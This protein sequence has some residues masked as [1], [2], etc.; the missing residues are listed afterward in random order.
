MS[1]DYIPEVYHGQVVLVSLDPS[2]SEFFPMLVERCDQ[3]GQVVGTAFTNG[4][5]FYIEGAKHENDPWWKSETNKV[6]A[7][8]EHIARWKTVASI[9]NRFADMDK[10]I[11]RVSMLE[12]DV[13]LLTSRSSPA[14]HRKKLVSSTPELTQEDIGSEDRLAEITDGSSV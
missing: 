7:Q 8:Q 2:S 6:L 12:R 11:E 4:N 9:E 1:I 14:T 10:L 3:R 13:T 5:G